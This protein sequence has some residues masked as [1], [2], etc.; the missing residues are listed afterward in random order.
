MGRI[1]KR[2]AEEIWD[3]YEKEGKIA[4]AGESPWGTAL[5]D[6]ASHVECVV[7]Y[8]QMDPDS[9]NA[10]REIIAEADAKLPRWRL[11]VGSFEGC[12][13]TAESA[14]K[15]AAPYSLDFLSYEKKIKK[16]FDPNLVS[17]YSWYV[18]PE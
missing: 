8:D 12:L 17:E 5:A 13:T 14:Q 3:K 9:V 11:A 7:V 4:L 15:A 10:V 18:S 1:S 2:A 6:W 16:A